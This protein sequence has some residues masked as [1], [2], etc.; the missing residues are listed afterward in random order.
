LVGAESLTAWKALTVDICD[1]C[2]VMNLDAIWI[3]VLIFFKKA[4]KG[5]GY[6]TSRC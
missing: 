5:Y 4:P 2:V 3:K 6:C 1:V